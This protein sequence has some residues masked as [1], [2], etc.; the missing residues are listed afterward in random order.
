MTMK[1]TSLCAPALLALLLSPLYA[2]E[3]TIVGFD[4]T[5][6]FFHPMGTDPAVADPT[7]N[8]TWFKT[9][10]SF[11]DAATG[12]IGDIATFDRGTGSGPLGYDT[13]DYMGTGGAEFSGF[14]QFLTQPATG[15]RGAAY[16][17]TTFTLPANANPWSGVRI[18]M[19]LDD[20]ALIYL[21]GILVA[22]VNK[23]NDTEAWGTAG[24]ALDTTATFNESGAS[25][26]DE[27]VI[28]SFFLN[29]AGTSTT[30]E[31][32]V[33]NPVNSL[34]AGSTHILAVSTRNNA[35][36]S[37]DMC[38]AL[39]LRADDAPLPFISAAATNV[40]RQGNGPGFADDTFTFDVTVSAN[41]MAAAVSWTSDNPAANGPVSGSY[42]PAVFSYSYLAQVDSGTLNVAKIKFTDATDPLF[43]TSI[44][45]TAPEAP[46]GP[47]LT[48]SAAT[49]SHGTGFEEAGMGLG[50][51]SR[52]NFN[53][54]LSFTS[55]GT[56][57]QDVMANGTGSKMLQFVGVNALMTTEAVRLDP[58]VRGV[59]AGVLLRTFT[60]TTTGFEFDD[61]LRIHVEGSPDGLVWA[62]RGSVVPA[63]YGND[64]ATSLNP[65][66]IDQLL[67]KVGPGT[68]GQPVSR[69]RLGWAAQGN[70]AG[71]ASDTLTIPAFTVPDAEPVKMEFT[72]RYSF[73]Y[74]IGATRWDGGAVAVAINGGPFTPVPGT[75]FTR[76]G[77]VGII[78][79]NN[80]LNGLEAF[81]GDSPNYSTGGM[82]T[83]IL[84]IPG[85]SPGDSCEVQFLGAWDEAVLA[86]SPNWEINNVKLTSNATVIYSNDF[87][88][89]DGGLVAT[90][91]WAF[92]NG[93]INPGPSYY[94]FTRLSI[95]VAAGDQFVR[96]RL[97]QPSN[98]ALSTSEFILIDQIKLEAGL[99]PL[100]D[101]DLD[102][103]SNGMEDFAGTSPT[104]PLSAFK[105]TSVVGPSPGVPGNQRATLTFPAPDFRTYRF[106]SS[107]N[108]LTWAD[109][110][111]RYGDPAVP[112][113]TFTG[114][115]STP[116]KF[117]RIAIVY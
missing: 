22:R 24:F 9:G 56:V 108:L 50:S 2:A 51:F 65:A 103:V 101:A 16:F 82:V 93:T 12:D 40:Q 5:W 30:A 113:L 25:A 57:V 86:S 33:I 105:V 89:G 34:E 115:A 20:G 99:D 28:Q 68:F 70:G 116:E 92:D 77:Y 47:P 61:S 63:L 64:P 67:V 112:S 91:G 15:N 72:H 37:S 97:Y 83:S 32:V 38:F 88:A 6:N 42:A 111:V 48:I 75:A 54:E 58:A 36:G 73:E 104:D 95:P 90:P 106:Q 44:S 49:P 45:V 55:N 84:T 81:N 17:R 76:E 85:L 39:E 117:W 29:A 98:I 52:R 7:W 74:D 46:P 31:S 114:E 10:A 8:T 109:V 96:M 66:G 62:D 102:G 43:T 4:N 71:P 1:F 60:N 3:Q 53:T 59:K 18:R 41:N 87:A 35:L 110:E 27:A 26:N 19:C 13:I 21:D 23:G 94:T 80:V 100:A 79:G 14:G 11:G 78:T 69:S 107:D